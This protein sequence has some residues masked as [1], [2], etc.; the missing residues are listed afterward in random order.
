MQTV[1]F[2]VT[3]IAVLGA[4]M[5]SAP[6]TQ[7]QQGS[8]YPETG[9][10]K[11]LVF[12]MG[13]FKNTEYTVATNHAIYRAQCTQVKKD[14]SREPECSF[15][16]KTITN[17][18]TVNF[19]VEN[20]FLMLPPGEQGKEQQLPIL[21]TELHP[22]PETPRP[23]Q[24]GVENGIVVAV[25]NYKNEQYLN[26][27]TGESCSSLPAHSGEPSPQAM[28]PPS[29]AGAIPPSGKVRIYGMA[30]TPE[31]ADEMLCMTSK[32]MPLDSFKL[33]TSDRVYDVTCMN[34]GPCQLNGQ[35]LRLG[36]KYF[37]RV[38]F[39]T[40]RIATEPGQFSDKSAFRV[41]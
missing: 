23:G 3:P 14:G 30:M 2:S 38:D 1:R 13:T 16:G 7:S 12:S 33:I 39:P 32:G 9:T 19:R 24:D 21:Q 11:L 6:P 17:G 41:R 10:V 5:F 37:V 26:S 27:L 20:D 15:N 25:G 35:P 34:E 40:M 22:Y 31:Q 4:L 18:D 29:S 8:V 36:G 28:T